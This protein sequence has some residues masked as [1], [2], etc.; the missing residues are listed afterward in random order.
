MSGA[1]QEQ[2]A[3][4][5][6]LR[7]VSGEIVRSPADGFTVVVDDEARLEAAVRHTP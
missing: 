4:A 7:G 6:L 5:L 2:L 1:A 3:R